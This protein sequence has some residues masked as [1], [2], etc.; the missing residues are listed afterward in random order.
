MSDP[1]PAEAVK[2]IASLFSGESRL[3]DDAVHALSEKYGK[4]DFISAP[5]PFAYT[6]YYR[7]EFG[8]SLIRRLVAFDRLIRP[9]SL[10]DV[11]LWTNSLERRLLAEGR[12]RVNIDPG[13]IAKAHLILSTGKGYS[14]RPYLR[15]GIYADLTLIY[16]NKA[17]ETLPWTYP[18]YAGGRMIGMLTR[19]REKYSL[20][21]KGKTE[22]DAP[23]AVDLPVSGE[24]LLDEETIQ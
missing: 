17:F 22:D 5:A 1:Q 13:Y 3:L 23:A 14:H 8:G 7:K 4:V 9:D 6:D 19:I 21:L 20:Q 12:R 24:N 11:K 10:P 2:L 18:D 16:R 15:D